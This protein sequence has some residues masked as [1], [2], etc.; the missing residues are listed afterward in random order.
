MRILFVDDDLRVLEGLRRALRPQRQQWE[1]TFA[2]GGPAGMAEIERGEFDV[3]ISDMRMPQVDG[4]ALLQHAAERMPGA[5]RIV[6]SGQ[7]D[8]DATRRAVRMAHLFLRKPCESA[9]LV[10]AIER[11]QRLHHLLA[12]P[13]LRGL[14][15]GVGTLPSPPRVYAALE[16]ALREPNAHSDVVT[17]IVASDGALTAKVI[18][19][20][21]SS[22]FGLTRRILRI[23]DAVSYLGVNT[24][25]TLVLAHELGQ[26]FE[27]VVA[28]GFSIER[29]QAHALLVAGIARRLSRTPA[30]ADEAF[31]AAML[32]DIGKLVLAALRPEYFAACCVEA[33]ERALPLHVVE[34]ERSRFSHAEIG[35]YMLGL[36]GF[37]FSIVEA[38]AYHHRPDRSPEGAPDTGPDEVLVALHTA[39]AL[40]HELAEPEQRRETTHLDQAFV[41]RVAATHLVPAWRDMAAAHI[42]SI[43]GDADVTSRHGEGQTR[44][45]GRLVA[46]RTA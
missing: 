11:V 31:M 26:A 28:P 32:H 44:S 10:G 3:V 15:G 42:A 6:L 12:D 18:Q 14:L 45:P 29:Y 30:S 43:A 9:V 36:W 8:S 16:R 19:L 24:I 22:F 25:R 20:V 27:P 21:N 37:P 38:V 46:C 39:D 7:T 2:P 13:T 40:A 23:E 5:V 41:S 34:L 1:M 33:D 4:V 17:R 35:A